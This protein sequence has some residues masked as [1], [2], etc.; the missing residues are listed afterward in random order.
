[1]VTTLVK[2]RARKSA[3]IGPANPHIPG[4]R[5]P[6]TRQTRASAL[7][8]RPHEGQRIAPLVLRNI[9][10]PS[11]I[12]GAAIVWHLAVLGRLGRLDAITLVEPATEIDQAA[13]EGAK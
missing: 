6:Q 5:R 3:R 12:G 2:L 9:G 10:F 11:T 8:R 13:G 1:M 4:F 7:V